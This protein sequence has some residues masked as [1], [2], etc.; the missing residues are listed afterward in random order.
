MNRKHVHACKACIIHAQAHAFL[1]TSRRSTCAS[2]A[3]HGAYLETSLDNSSYSIPHIRSAR[4]SVD[5]VW[6]CTN[7]TMA[8][9]PWAH[10]LAN[11]RSISAWG[12]GAISSNCASIYKSH[13]ENLHKSEYDFAAHISNTEVQQKANHCIQ[14]T[15]SHCTRWRPTGVPGK[16]IARGGKS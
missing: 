2:L 16:H 15:S 10:R 4:L 3:W 5:G 11:S 7:H 1:R 12:G 6:F 8:W 13:T 14:K 9:E